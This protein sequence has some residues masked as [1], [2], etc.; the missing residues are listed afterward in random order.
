MKIADPVKVTEEGNLLVRSTELSE[1]CRRRGYQYE[2]TINLYSFSFD[3]KGTK[4]H[5][6]LSESGFLE[7]LKKITHKKTQYRKNSNN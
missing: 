4:E 5:L 3:K 2:W 7:W 1:E 6:G